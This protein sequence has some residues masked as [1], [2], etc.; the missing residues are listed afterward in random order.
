MKRLFTFVTLLAATALVSCSSTSQVSLDYSPDPGRV[1][2]GQPE[3]ATR[4]FRDRRDME[5]T[6]LGTV[7]T[8]IGTPLENV[9]TRVPV[10]QVVTNAFG[11]GLQARGMLTAPRSSR[12]IVTGEVLDLYCQ[13]LV[14]PYGYARVRVTVLESASGQIIHSKVYTGERSSGM[15]VPGS[16]S[17]VPLLR[18]LV[19][20]ALQDA[21]DRALDDSEMRGRLNDGMSLEP[22]RPTI[23]I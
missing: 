2:P 6:D 7:R 15:Y 16:G 20:G 9:Q 21:V 18:D 22:T 17:P 8:Q 10:S 5:P 3:F 14:R 23:T 13:M 4:E 1:R 11:Y 12:Y 19:S